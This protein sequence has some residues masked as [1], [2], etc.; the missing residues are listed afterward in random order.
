MKSLLTVLSLILFTTFCC[1]GA[2]P[3]E[4]APNL[5]TLLTRLETPGAV[6]ELDLVQFESAARDAAARGVPLDVPRMLRIVD[7]TGLP[8]QVR[9]ASLRVVVE[10]GKQ[11]EEVLA[12]LAHRGRV[13]FSIAAR[14]PDARDPEEQSRSAGFA[15]IFWMGLQ[16]YPHTAILGVPEAIEFIVDLAGSSDGTI[17]LNVPQNALALLLSLKLPPDTASGYAVSILRSRHPAT[18]SLW[19]VASFG[20]MVLP[21]HYELLRTMVRDA[22]D[23][24]EIFP[25]GSAYVLAHVG[26]AW[27]GEELTRRA[28]RVTGT[29]QASRYLLHDYERAIVMVRA[30]SKEDGLLELVRT[31][32]ARL[33][34]TLPVYDEELRRW[35]LNRAVEVGT[36]P[37][38][39]RQAI[40]DFAASATTA[41]RSI[42]IEKLRSMH[43]SSTL[44]WLKE[45]GLKNGVLRDGDLAEVHP[46]PSHG[47][48]TK[49]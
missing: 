19:E 16:S 30:Q 42:Q 7:D 2:E 23:E 48:L 31:L 36:A 12:V 13:W 27:V 14:G 41:M 26:D 46:H 35:A 20:S 47:R 45:W 32:P 38:E 17:D 8:W 18:S 29:D 25:W 34:R 6:T 1:D 43:T 39:V 28:A 11:S 37:Q 49:D 10:F 5:D 4:P 24:A 15:W 22:G 33:V 40:L 21:E 44:F 9:T 3:R